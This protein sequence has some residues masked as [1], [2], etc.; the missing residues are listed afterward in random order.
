M[1]GLVLSRPVRFRVAVSQEDREAAFRLR[2]RAIA[3]HSWARHEDY[4]DGLETDHRDDNALHIVGWDGAIPVAAARLIFPATGQRLPTEE[5]FDLEIEP[6]GRVVDMGRVTVEPAYSS[7][8]HRVLAGLMA[9][10]WREIASHGYTDACGAFA[11]RA[12]IRIY[13]HMGFKIRILAPAR[14]YWGGE[15]FPILFDVLGS[16]EALARRWG[17]ARS[18]EASESAWIGGEQ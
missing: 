11:S 6:T 16:A 18:D 15:R 14:P 5:A 12:T 3:H 8:Q 9:F 4:P 2:Y 7:I 13:Q 1:H 10:A 17:T